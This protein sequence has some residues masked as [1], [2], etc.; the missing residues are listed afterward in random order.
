MPTIEQLKAEYDGEWLIVLVTDW[1]KSGII[2]GELFHHS[3]DKDEIVRKMGEI[4]K[5]KNKN[6]Y[7]AV[8]YAGQLVPEGTG[9]LL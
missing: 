8:L 9:V 7:M 2:E 3:N 1:D 5:S 6:Y 4:P